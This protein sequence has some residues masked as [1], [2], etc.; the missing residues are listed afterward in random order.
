MYRPNKR[1]HMYKVYQKINVALAI[2]NSDLCKPP[3]IQNQL[4]HNSHKNNNQQVKF[5]RIICVRTNGCG[6]YKFIKSQKQRA[7]WLL[8][9]AWKPPRRR[10]EGLHTKRALPHTYKCRLGLHWKLLISCL[11]YN[12]MTYLF[13]NSH[14]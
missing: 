4:G 5:L 8:Q 11:R 13:I 12:L 2:H 3:F 6:G 1:K 9:V 7:V 14:R 10:V